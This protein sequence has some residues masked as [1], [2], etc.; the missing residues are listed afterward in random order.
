MPARQRWR[1]PGSVWAIDHGEPPQPIDGH[2]RQILAVR[3]LA[4]G[5]QLAWTP[6]AE[7]TAAEAVPVLQAL[8]LEYGAP[9]ALKSDNGSAFKS[10]DFGAWLSEHLVVPLLSPVRMPRYNGACEA[11]IGAAKRRTEYLAA[12]QGRYLDWTTNDLH[13]AQRWA[14]EES[15]PGGFAA[16]TPASRFAARVPIDDIERDTFRAAVLQYERERN[17]EASTRGDALTDMLLAIHH[18][19]AVRHVLVEHGYLDI[20]RRSVPQPL[21]AKKCAKIK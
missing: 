21:P 3:D 10:G 16:G 2:F 8:T 9:L 12:R 18:R 17:Q 4:S 1:R 11:G 6:V 7:A 14:N 15:Y 20:T 19:R 5:M 13:A